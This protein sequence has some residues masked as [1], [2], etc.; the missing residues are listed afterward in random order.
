MSKRAFIYAAGAH[1]YEDVSLYS[2]IKRKEDDLII[3]AYGG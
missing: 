2:R 3:C 1:T